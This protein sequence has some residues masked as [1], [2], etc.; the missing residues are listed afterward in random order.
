[1]RPVYFRISPR[2]SSR[3]S[4]SSRRGR[5]NGSQDGGC[6]G[7]GDG[8]YDGDYHVLGYRRRRW[9]AFFV[10][11]PSFLYRGVSGTAAGTT[12]ACMR[13]SSSSG[14]A[15]CRIH[16]FAGRSRSRRRVLVI[17]AQYRSSRVLPFI[18]YT[19]HISCS[20]WMCMPACIVHVPLEF[21]VVVVVSRPSKPWI[22]SISKSISTSVLPL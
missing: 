5:G 13:C 11:T 16:Q 17:I 14:K 7:E 1:M 10:V 9:T 3:S 2:C 6:V 21:E 18:E 8:G 15:R 12:I 19:V 20:I 4:R 22:S